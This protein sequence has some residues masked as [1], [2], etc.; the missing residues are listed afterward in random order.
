MKIGLL[1]G[2]FNPPHFGHLGISKDALELL[3]LYEI[4]WLPTK[5]NPLKDTKNL[6]FDER[7]NLCKEITQNEA[8]ILVK[9]WEKEIKNS[10]FIDLLE[11][12]LEKTP[13]TQFYLLM[14]ADNLKNFH[15]W[16]RWQDI[17]K[18]VQIAVFERENLEKEVK[19]TK[20]YD[21]CEKLS[22][23]D[24]KDHLIFLKNKKY[25]VSSTKIRN[26][27]DKND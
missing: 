10:Y 9:D 12:I 7:L 26:N 18:L 24:Q 22:Q 6:D 15:L 1:G 14:G 17:I 20:I 16:H 19:N 8:K 11:L 23:K 13:K 4:W 25:D 3:K 27:K 21:F 5:Q 2:S